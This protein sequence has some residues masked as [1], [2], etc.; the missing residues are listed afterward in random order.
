MS[1]AAFALGWLAGRS[2]ATGAGGRLTARV[3]LG[4]MTKEPWRAKVNRHFELVGNQFLDAVKADEFKRVMGAPSRT[5]AIGDHVYW[6]YD[7]S[8]GVIQ[9]VT[10]ASSL[11]SMGIFFGARINEL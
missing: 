3:G 5:Q 7:C 6:Y 1:L 9:I 2:T 4:R 11:H 10:G 8:D